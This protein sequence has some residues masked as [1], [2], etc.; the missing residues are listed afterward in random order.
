MKSLKILDMKIRSEMVAKYSSG[1]SQ[2]EIAKQYGISQ[3]DVC[4]ILR[5]TEG[6]KPRNRAKRNQAGASHPLWKAE[7]IAY[8]GAHS[9]VKRYRGTPSKCEHCHSEDSALTFDWANLTG[10]FGDTED[11]VRLC[12]SC[13]RKFDDSRRPPRKCQAKPGTRSCIRCG[14][15]IGRRKVCATAAL[16]K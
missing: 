9:R 1:A 6:Y 10:R 4:L 7:G 14:R 12:R 5:N 13:H 16:P 11:Y 15:F 3:P 2:S 8:K